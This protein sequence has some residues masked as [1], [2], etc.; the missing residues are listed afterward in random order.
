MNVR[1]SDFDTLLAEWLEDDPNVAS[2]APVEAAVDF[3]RNHP[4]HRDWLAF[5]RRDAMSSRTTTGL[6]TVAIAVALAAVL[7]VAIGGA[8]LI[9][10]TPEPTATP[11]PSPSAIPTAT[12]VAAR[13]LPRGGALTSGQYS[14]ELPESTVT[15][16]FTIEDGWTSG[17]WYLMNPPALDKAVIFMAIANV[18]EDICAADGGVATASELPDPPIGPTVDDLVEA[19]DA[20]ANTDMLRAADV[21]VGGYSGKRVTLT[22]TDPY[23]DHCIGDFPRPMWVDPSGEPG[24]SMQPGQRDIMWILDVQGQRVAIIATQSNQADADATES[25]ANVIRSMEFAVD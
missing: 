6:R 4:R 25:I 17:G 13:P 21:V 14:T 2:A 10:S 1:D 11:I 24:R 5:L 8:V 3:A 15:A 12:P 16:T 20:Q 22:E 7:A 18:Y 23:A 9:G 19:L